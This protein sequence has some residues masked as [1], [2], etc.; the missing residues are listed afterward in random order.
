M[1]VLSEEK[2]TYIFEPDEQ[3]FAQAF[4]ESAN[5]KFCDQTKDKHG[6][7]IEEI[8]LEHGLFDERI[9]VIVYYRREKWVNLNKKK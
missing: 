4:Y 6:R 1:R 7:V 5:R 8:A 2:R 9:S 3:K